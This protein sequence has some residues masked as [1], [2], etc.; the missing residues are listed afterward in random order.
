MYKI[1]VSLSMAS[2]YIIKD[3]AGNFLGKD[4]KMTR[5][6]S[7]SNIT[8]ERYNSPDKS[9]TQRLVGILRADDNRILYREGNKVIYKTQ[10]SFNSSITSDDLNEKLHY[11]FV[12]VKVRPGVFMIKNGMDCLNSAGEGP[13]KVGKCDKDKSHFKIIENFTTLKK[14]IIADSNNGIRSAVNDLKSE[15]NPKL[16]SMKSTSQKLEDISDSGTDL[17]SESDIEK[18]ID[19]P[20]ERLLNLLQDLKTQ[21]YSNDSLMESENTTQSQNPKKPTNGITAPIRAPDQMHI[22]QSFSP[23]NGPKSPNFQNRPSHQNQLLSQASSQMVPIFSNQP[24]EL[25][26]NQFQPPSI[27]RSPQNTPNQFHQANNSEHSIINYNQ[28]PPAGDNSL[29][30]LATTLLLLSDDD[31]ANA[32]ILSLLMQANIDGSTKLKN[33]ELSNLSNTLLMKM[34]LKKN[35]Q[36]SFEKPLTRE[37]VSIEHRVQYIQDML[38]KLTM[39]KV[40]TEVVLKELAKKEKAKPSPKVGGLPGLFGKMASA[41]PMGMAVNAATEAASAA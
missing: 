38:F 41:T 15:L 35:R 19:D 33:K 4:L 40:A 11:L 18:P 10:D 27:N 31:G 6:G 8:F 29:T 14:R 7:F 23:L 16:D 25:A 20:K 1:L 28:T 13:L 3:K 36:S 24:L 34:I 5:K 21:N 9:T 2:C 37:D 30:S 17:S 12:P 32:A 26:S 39:E 22:Q